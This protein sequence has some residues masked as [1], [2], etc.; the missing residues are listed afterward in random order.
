[1]DFA[2]EVKAAADIV[3]VVGTHVRLR[4][5]GGNRFIGLCPFHSEKTPS[6]TVHGGL[7]FYKCFGCG[8]SGDVFS[9]LME[10]QGLSFVE[11]LRVLAAQQGRSMPQAGKGPGLDA[12]ARK[13]EQLL[14]I[15]ALAQEFFVSQLRSATGAG[16]MR[17]LRARGIGKPEIDEFGLG[18]AP[19]RQGLKEHFKN[20]GL[21]RGDVR[22]SGLIGESEKDRSLYDRF[23]DRLMFPIHSDMG[24]LIGYGGRILDPDKQPKYLNSPETPIY[25]KHAVLYN[26]HRARTAMR[27][28]SRVVLVEGYMDVIGVWKAGIRNAVATC[29]TALTTQQIGV[30]RRHCDTVVVNFDSDRAGQA[31]AERSVELLLREGMNVRVL[32]LPG[33][34][35]PDEF[36]SQHGAEEYRRQLDRA[37]RFFHWLLDRSRQQ[38]DLATAEG[39]TAVFEKLLPSVIL[40]PEAV[41]RATTV[42]ELAEHIGLPQGVAL[43]RL[44]S[45][46][47]QGERTADRGTP[48]PDGLSPGERLLVVLLANDGQARRELLEE[49]HDI[50][51]GALSSQ[52][53]LAA[54]RA[55]ENSGDGYHH[56]A[57]EGRLEDEDRERLARLVLDG[58]RPVPTI[59]EGR[60]ALTALRLKVT[61]DRY[62]DLLRGIAEAERL[63]DKDKLAEML[64]QIKRMEPDLGLAER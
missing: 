48:Q 39:R 17:Y 9:F 3:T 40:L 4:Q 59:D 32:E 2:Q 20:R 10:I 52:R 1:M 56:S 58:D 43:N 23:R 13:R 31:A 27:Q 24:K 26:L 38:F 53:I 6:F 12:G 36:C 8:K 51:S 42:V 63:G 47:N 44:R 45:A 15:H 55:V 14:R 46:T 11:S 34:L 5:Q 22:D 28:S 41:Q 35:D 62:R 57:V 61:R 21:K 33:G 16:A 30:I 60:E 64:D 25:R 49:A 29:G 37:P 50:A 7:Q 19:P 54:M 18:Y